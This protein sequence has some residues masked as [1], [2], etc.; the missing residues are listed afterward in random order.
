MANETMGNIKRGVG[1][2]TGSESL[3]Q[4]GLDQ[5]R[6]SEAQHREGERRGDQGNDL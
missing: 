5:E 6:R 3:R 1:N 2:L 4:S